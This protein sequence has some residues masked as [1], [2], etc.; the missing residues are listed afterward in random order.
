MYK[1][2]KQNSS[3]SSYTTLYNAQG[4][5][6]NTVTGSTNIAKLKYIINTTK[7]STSTTKIPIQTGQRKDIYNMD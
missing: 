7:K 4:I 1:Q 6:Q 2:N 3:V 5:Y